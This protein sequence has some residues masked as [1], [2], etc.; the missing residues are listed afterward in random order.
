MSNEWMYHKR[1]SITV[2]ITSKGKDVFSKLDKELEDTGSISGHRENWVYFE[3]LG[4]LKTSSVWSSGRPS[5]ISLSALISWIDEN[6][7]LEGVSY[8]TVGNAITSM[9][10]ENLIVITGP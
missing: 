7:D 2:E 1:D 6:P 10:K 3:V 5:P 4:Y 8:M 9:I